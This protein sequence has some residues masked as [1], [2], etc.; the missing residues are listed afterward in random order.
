MTKILAQVLEKNNLPGSLCALVCGGTEVGESMAADKRLD[1]V[2]F[3]GSTAVMFKI[4]FLN[5]DRQKGRCHSAR[6]LWQIHSWTW[7]QQCH[8]WY[9]KK[10][11][12]ELVAEDAD[13]DL[14]VRSIVFAAVGTAGQRCTTTRRLVR[15]LI[16]HQVYSICM[17]QF[18]SK[19]LSDWSKPMD[20]WRL[21]TLFKMVSFV[22]LF[23]QSK[24]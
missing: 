9:T 4:L 17:N 24:L 2:S 21:A 19:F 23:I 3:T 12:L 8:H 16:F 13:L 18:M 1:I 20:K 15:I 5:L 11:Q 10:L 14:A 7:R 22:V 6:A